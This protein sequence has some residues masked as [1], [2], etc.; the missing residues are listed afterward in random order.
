VYFSDSFSQ[1]SDAIP[2][3]TRTI[4]K[5]MQRHHA[6]EKIALP[7]TLKYENWEEDWKR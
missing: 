1:I 6:G 4:I 2:W 3:A 5:L 7:I